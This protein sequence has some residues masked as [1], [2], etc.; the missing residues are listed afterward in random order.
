MALSLKK[1]N[2]G[3]YDIE[4][5]VDRSG[6]MGESEGRKTR[7][8]IVLDWGL[9]LF[10]ELEKFDDDG[11]TLVLFD[12]Q[13]EIYENTTFAAIKD[14]FRAAGPRNST[15]TAGVIDLRANDYLDQRLG[16][17]GTSG[18][19]GFGGKKDGPA[20]PKVKPRI[21]LVA[22]DG[23]PNDLG[24]LIQVIVAITKRMSAGGLTKDDLVI[25]F[26]QVG[27]DDGAKEA[28]DTLNNG[29]FSIIRDLKEPLRQF[30]LLNDSP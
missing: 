8:Q 27:N 13:F 3:S 28:L 5:L 22:T 12:D 4:F 15:D 17:K 21:L 7:W 14:I 20:N 25:S 1:R 23:T 11:A 30:A 10:P 9:V 24:K 19:F 6:S 16:K 18:L 26:I 2:L 29:L